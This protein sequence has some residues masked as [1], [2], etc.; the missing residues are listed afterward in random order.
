V[1]IA[2]ASVLRC[3]GKGFD[4]D[5]YKISRQWVFRRRDLVFTLYD[6]KSTDLYE[7]GLWTPSELW[8]S[9]WPFDLHVG[10][11]HPATERDVEEFVDF[12][13]RATSAA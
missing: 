4:G 2:P 3:F 12:V 8:A 7:R 6:W 9:V 10:S 1:Q 13:Q 5:G 11:K